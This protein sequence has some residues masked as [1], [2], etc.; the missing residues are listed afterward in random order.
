MQGR[1]YGGAVDVK[2]AATYAPGPATPGLTFGHTLAS[3]PPPP[4]HLAAPLINIHASAPAPPSPSILPSFFSP[5]V[6]GSFV[7]A[8]KSVQCLSTEEE[9]SN[10]PRATQQTIN[11]YFDVMTR[12]GDF[13]VYTPTMSHG[14]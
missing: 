4:S 9:P 13:A 14:P 8:G 1:R 3:S 11:H 10:V 7:E 6:V 5:L 2:R 12:G